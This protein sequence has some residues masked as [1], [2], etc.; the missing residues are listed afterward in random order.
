MPSID[1]G[2]N[3]KT[4][5]MLPNGFWKFLV[6]IVKELEGLLMCDKAYCIKI[7]HIVSSRTPVTVER[8]AQGPSESPVPMPG[9]T[10][11]KMKRQLVYTLYLC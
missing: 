5:H 6:H 7:A 2:S 1:Y 11:K 10:V 3:K 8:A 9:C 4:E